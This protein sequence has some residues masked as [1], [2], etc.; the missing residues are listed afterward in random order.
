MSPRGNCRQ[1]TRIRRYRPYWRPGSDFFFFDDKGYAPVR[2]LCSLS[3]TL[4]QMHPRIDCDAHAAQPAMS[5]QDRKYMRICANIYAAIIREIM[6]LSRF[7]RALL[8]K[9]DKK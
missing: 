2:G 3:V 6:N 4:S 7:S 1:A 9:L 8:E 5:K